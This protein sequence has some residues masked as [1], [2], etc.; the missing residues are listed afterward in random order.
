MI[1][2]SE[3]DRSQAWAL[4]F[5]GM[6]AVLLCL[7]HNLP[8]LTLSETTSPESHR[9]LTFRDLIAIQPDDLLNLTDKDRKH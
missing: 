4:I 5:D 7:I 3:T 8:E 1:P 2:F 6:L 9:S